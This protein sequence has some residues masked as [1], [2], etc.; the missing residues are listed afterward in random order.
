MLTK[1]LFAIG[2]SRKHYN[3]RLRRF[4]ASCMQSQ[5][6]FHIHALLERTTVEPIQRKNGRLSNL[7]KSIDEITRSFQKSQCCVQA[8]RETWA[9][10]KQNGNVQMVTS[11]IEKR[12]SSAVVREEENGVVDRTPSTSFRENWAGGKWGGNTQFQI[13]QNPRCLS[14][15]DSLSFAWDT[16]IYFHY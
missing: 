16:V 14:T 3:N 8:R 13:R 10:T 12:A 5:K 1:L 2:Y 6:I 9:E 4:T 7:T 15:W 11:S